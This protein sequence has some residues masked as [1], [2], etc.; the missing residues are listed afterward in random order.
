[1]VASWLH[2]PK[3]VLYVFGYCCCI[4]NHSTNVAYHIQKCMSQPSLLTCKVMETYQCTNYRNLFVA[5]RWRHNGHDSVSNH[6]R[7]DCLLNCLSRRRSKKT[8]KLRVTGLC[9][10]NWQET[11]EFPAQKASDA[12]NVSIWWRHH[13]ASTIITAMNSTH[14][15]SVVWKTIRVALTIVYKYT[16]NIG[17]GS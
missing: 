16:I 11:G 6:Q 15:L 9:A 2:Y 7:H 1:M 13:G 17:Q 4:G 3:N 14:D 12:E 8:S 5:L 10:G